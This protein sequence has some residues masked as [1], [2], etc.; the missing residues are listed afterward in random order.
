MFGS[1][2]IALDAICQSDTM[3]DSSPRR[4]EMT[5]PSTNTWSPRST[6]SFHRWSDSSPTAASDTIAWM[7]L[8]SPACS[9]AKQSLPVLRLKTMRPA[10]AAVTPVSAPASRSPNRAR[11]AGI[12][13]VIGRLTGYGAARGIR[14]LLDEALA[15]GQ[16]HG[17]LLEDVCD[18]AVRLLGSAVVG[19]ADAAA[20][21]VGSVMAGAP[22][23][24]GTLQSIASGIGVGRDRCFAG[25]P[26]AS[27]TGK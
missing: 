27:S 14:P 11:S 9:V 18:S 5:S 23:Q 20:G 1:G 26:R 13:S 17:L 24:R 8:P 16:A 6:S 3:I 25:P 12:V 4:L 21:A 10:T 7:R 22:R 2:R 15:L 19:S